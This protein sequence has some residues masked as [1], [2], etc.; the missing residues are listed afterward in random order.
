MINDLPKEFLEKGFKYPEA[1]TKIVE[2][3]LIDFDYWYIMNEDQALNRLRGL[4][5]RYPK[6][7]LVP[8]A[9]RDDNDDIACFD[10]NQPNKV[11][12]IHDFA[13]SGY[14]QKKTYDNL[15][16]WL[17]DAINEFIEKNK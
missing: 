6:R 14:E 12:I 7:Y 17:R 11:Q 5:Q 3:N 16:E 8:F 13:S 15:W 9:K 4:R 2:L 10:L 1:Y